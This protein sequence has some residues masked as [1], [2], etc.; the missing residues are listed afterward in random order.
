VCVCVCVC[1]CHPDIC[2]YTA[3]R[4]AGSVGLAVSQDPTGN[5]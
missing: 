4:A 2:R 3:V 1:V 5:K